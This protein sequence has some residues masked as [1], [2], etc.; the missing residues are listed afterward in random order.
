MF[1]DLVRLS[2]LLKQACALDCNEYIRAS[3]FFVMQRK[4]FRGLYHISILV[5]GV[6]MGGHSHVK[7]VSVAEYF[8]GIGGIAQLCLHF[9]QFIIGKI[10][11]MAA[12]AACI[13][14]LS[15]CNRCYGAQYADGRSHHEYTLHI[16]FLHS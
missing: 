11:Q 16:P 10:I 3:V 9:S 13:S 15:R 12:S 6:L 7:P 5:H 1:K 8:G 4:A 14:N 2:F